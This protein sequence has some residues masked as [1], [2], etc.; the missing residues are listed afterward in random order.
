M[1]A[2]V[3]KTIVTK[4]SKPRDVM[5]IPTDKPTITLIAAA[6]KQGKSY[7]IRYIITSMCGAGHFSYGVCFS[8]T[9][10]FNGDYNYLPEK[11]VHAEYS[12][13]KLEDIMRFQQR[14]N[15]GAMFIVFD[16]MTGQ[17]NMNSKTFMRFIQAYRHY[18]ITVL[19]A[20]HMINKVSTLFREC[21]T[22]AII[23]RQRTKRS[24]DALHEN[25]FGD[26]DKNDLA[27]FVSKYTSRDYHYL[28]V[29][30]G[31]GEY[32]SGSAPANYPMKRI[33]Y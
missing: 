4:T 12:D 29:D 26:I 13:A 3:P 7:L 28:M 32:S 30:V 19:F 15:A 20:T 2:G 14:P 18:K 8:S 25:F 5:I 23:F 33:N 9:G 1:Q 16:D 17:V 21:T 24:Y 31:T 22:T 6:P 11:Y 27:G 10:K